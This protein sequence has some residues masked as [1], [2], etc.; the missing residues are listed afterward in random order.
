M[1]YYYKVFGFVLRCEHEIRQ[2]LLVETDGE[3]DLDIVFA[4]IPETVL[5]EIEDK[6][7]A[8]YCKWNGD[9]MWFRNSFAYFV[10][11]RSGKMVIQNNSDSEILF[12]LQFVLGYGISV[13]AHLKEMVALHCGAVSINGK[14]V[15]ITGASGAGKSTVT[16]E[17]LADGAKM[18]SDDVIA[19]GYLQEEEGQAYA[20]P[21]FP[22]QK[23][24]RDAALQR[25]YSLEDLIY[26]DPEKDKFAVD[27]REIFES[28]PQRFHSLFM[29]QWYDNENESYK[30]LNNQ[31]QCKKI[32]GFQK[33]SVI[34]NSLFLG[35]MLDAIGLPA[36][37]FQLCVDL[38][39]DVN[40]YLI[41]RPKGV[42]TMEQVKQ[43]IYQMIGEYV[44][45]EKRFLCNSGSC[46]E[47]NNARYT[48]VKQF[49]F[50]RVI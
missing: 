3:Y 13:F 17:L 1:Y 6:E 26:I 2:L 37:Q 34:V 48:G 11:Y 50:A 14:A 46:G 47:K 40:I 38:A 16:T 49:F 42:D 32:E 29:L 33:V 24:C 44:E 4:Q 23:L 25:G 31:V 21:A 18:L 19:V 28:N 43:I 9:Y 12:L 41:Q 35:M 10:V 15:A 45:Y 39:S 5:V 30:A 7:N 36:E 8:P 27:R 22:Q 20:F